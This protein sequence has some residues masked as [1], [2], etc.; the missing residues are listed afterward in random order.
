MAALNFPNTPANGQKWTDPGGQPWVYETATNSWTAEGAPV[1]GMVYK[2]GLDITAAPPSGAQGGWV[3][4]VTTGGAVNAGFTGLTGP[5]LAQS[6]IIFDGA[7][8]QVQNPPGVWNRTGT[9][10]SP[11]TAGDQVHTA[12]GKLTVGGTAAAP[13]I[14]IKAD[15][16]IVANTDGL[17]YDAATKRLAIGTTP[18]DTLTVNG[19]IDI[20]ANY[21]INLGSDQ[22]GGATLNYNPNGNLD[23]A[24]RS[25]FSTVFLS[26]FGGSERAR[27]DSSGRLLVG[28]SST[29]D[30]T[31]LLLQGNAV[32]LTGGAII[33]LCNGKA[34]PVN[35]EATGIIRFSDN[36][37][38]EAAT[39]MAARDGG[40]WSS[41]S[42]PTRLTF[43]TTADGESSPTERMRIDN[44]GDIT[45]GNNASLNYQL[46]LLV[47]GGADRSLLLAGI[48]GV[49]NGLQVNYINTG[50]ALSVKF[51]N[52]TTTASA[53]NA[54]LDSAD[55]NRI[56]RS[57]SSLRYKKDVE[58]I[59]QLKADAV[60][61]LRPVWYRSKAADDRSNWSWYGL[62]AEEVAAVE[63][64]LVHWTYLDEDYE[65][66]EVDGAIKKTPK[67]HAE[68]VP[69][70]VQYDRLTV[71]LL[72]VVKRQNERIE[73]LE[74]KVAALEGV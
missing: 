66:E 13:N 45:I 1:P 18:T 42:K 47:A 17:V 21:T 38:A 14:E 48:S 4:T 35:G 9:V 19:G 73:T 30:S 25:G 15:G 16:G 20:P 74:A 28:T 40:T 26:T 67:P 50:T 37:H 7:N 24:P 39:I 8:W 72:D 32:D 71:L 11:A 57:T 6:Q 69:D 55:G 3:Y 49:S 10:L 59:D 33:N 54:F 44:A 31:R 70:G 58:D 61:S 22:G 29:S 56:Y 53:A 60:L 51:N 41:T 2:G 43:S 62:I 27:I 63:P 23:I 65:I 12:T 68:L 64:R 36:T 34:E 5:I 46:G 52:I